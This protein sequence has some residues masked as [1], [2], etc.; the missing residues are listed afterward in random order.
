[1]TCPYNTDATYPYDVCVGTGCTVCDPNN[2]MHM[3][4]H[5]HERVQA[6]PGKMFGDL[7]PASPGMLPDSG[8]TYPTANNVPQ[9]R[10]AVPCADRNEVRAGLC[11]VV[12][13]QPD[14]APGVRNAQSR[15]GVAG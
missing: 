14:R 7:E 3:I 8:Q 11:V 12:S 10:F 2:P 4:R 13:R 5:D 9:Q 1:M 6:N 15:T